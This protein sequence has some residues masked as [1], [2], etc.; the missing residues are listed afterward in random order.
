MPGW[1]SRALRIRGGALAGALVI[2][3]ATATIAAA[4]GQVMATALG[5]PGAGRFAT[6]DEVVRANPT[7]RLGGDKLAVA[8][9]CSRPTR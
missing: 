6:A 2:L 1:T 9:R 7:V 3:A 4:A 8:P 5:A